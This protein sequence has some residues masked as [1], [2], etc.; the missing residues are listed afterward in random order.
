MRHVA[1]EETPQERGGDP[2]LVVG[3]KGGGVV[4]H[5]GP[6]DDRRDAQVAAGPQG[7]PDGHAEET[8]GEVGGVLGDLGDP[9][10]PAAALALL[11]DHDQ[12]EGGTDQRRDGPGN[13]PAAHFFLEGKGVVLVAP[14][15][16]VFEFSADDELDHGTG[17]HVDAVGDDTAVH[18][19]GVH[20]NRPL[21]LDHVFGVIEGLQDQ[22]LDHTD[23]HSDGRVLLLVQFSRHPVL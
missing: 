14:G 1:P 10:R 9:C 19:G 2:R 18:N 12:L 17:P 15:N 5:E 3:V 22:N 6:A 11:L 7:L 16:G 20:G 21:L 8:A 4:F 13:D 23:R